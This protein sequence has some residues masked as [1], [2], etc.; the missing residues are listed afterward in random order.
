MT[1]YANGLP[2]LG[3]EEARRLRA[4]IQSCVE[5]L[6]VIGQSLRN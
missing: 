5:R 2:L 4:L 1:G 3:S 6:T